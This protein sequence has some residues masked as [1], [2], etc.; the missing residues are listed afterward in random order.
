MYNKIYP[1]ITRRVSAYDFES[2]WWKLNKGSAGMQTL[3]KNANYVRPITIFISIS[4]FQSAVCRCCCCFLLHHTHFILCLF[5]FMLSESFALS[6]YLFLPL[7]MC[8]SVLVIF[9]FHTLLGFFCCVRLLRILVHI[10]MAKSLHFSAPNSFFL[11][12]FISLFCVGPAR[13]HIFQLC[14]SLILRI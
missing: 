4:S 2:N 14:L 11:S 6:V 5:I 9:V 10:D 3:L 13:A 7:C 8:W 12:V 1:S